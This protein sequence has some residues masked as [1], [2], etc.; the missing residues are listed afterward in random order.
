[1][2]KRNSFEKNGGAASTSKPSRK[3]CTVETIY[4]C[5]LA[6]T[7][8]LNQYIPVREIFVII[9]VSNCKLY[10]PVI[11]IVAHNMPMNPN[12]AHMISAF[13]YIR[14]TLWI[15]CYWRETASAITKRRETG[16]QCAWVEFK[17]MLWTK[18]KQI[19]RDVLHLWV[20]ASSHL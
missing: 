4:C 13:H 11:H 18:I 1:M 16:T 5:L 7:W 17:L 10:S 3:H 14:I 20:A 6:E 8:M 19:A 9:V 15:I 12:R 2:K